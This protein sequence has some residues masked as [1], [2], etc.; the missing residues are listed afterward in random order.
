MSDNLHQLPS[1]ISLDLDAEKRPESEIKPPFVAM[2]KGRE[3]TMTDPAELDWRELI[4]LESPTEFL[5][6]SLS[7]ED[8][9]FLLEQDLPGW[10]FNRLMESYYSHYDLEEKVRKARQQQRLASSV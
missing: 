6:L 10:K 1:N 5:R 3:I 2:V 9:K 4:L 7:A 8:R